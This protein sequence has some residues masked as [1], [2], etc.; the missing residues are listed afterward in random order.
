MSRGKIEVEGFVLL[1]WSKAPLG[2][3]WANNFL[4]KL[5][6]ILHLSKNR[7]IQDAVM[8]LHFKMFS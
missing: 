6:L 5:I 2:K 3:C 8:G 1:P 7:K 4:I